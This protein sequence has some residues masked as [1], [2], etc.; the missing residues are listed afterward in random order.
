M[1]Q[2]K[3]ALANGKLFESSSKS[4]IAILIS[5]KTGKFLQLYPINV[6]CN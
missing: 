1:I 2:G 6:F 4:K 5:E 3:T